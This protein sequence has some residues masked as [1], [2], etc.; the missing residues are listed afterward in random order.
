MC[1]QIIESPSGYR[2]FQEVKPFPSY[3]ELIEPLE[4]EELGKGIE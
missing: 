3:Q 1:L 2:Y 4:A